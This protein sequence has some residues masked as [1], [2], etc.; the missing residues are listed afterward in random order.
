MAGPHT[1]L[2]GAVLGTPAFM[3]PE[4]ARGKWDDVDATSDLWAIG[5][6]LFMLLT[7]RSVRDEAE[8][9]NEALMYAM[10][11]PVPPV[12][13]LIPGLPASIAS[14]IDRAL[15]FEKA[16]RFADAR[17]MKTALERAL[18]LTDK[19][20]WD[21]ILD[22]SPRGLNAT[23]GPTPFVHIR[24]PEGL[25][26]AGQLGN[27]T[28]SSRPPEMSAIPMTPAPAKLPMFAGPIVPRTPSPARTPAAA[29][30]TLSRAPLARTVIGSFVVAL[31]IGV[32]AAAVWLSQDPPAARSPSAPPPSPG[33]VDSLPA[34]AIAPASSANGTN[35]NPDNAAPQASGTSADAGPDK[36]AGAAKPRGTARPPVTAKPPVDP[37]D[38]GRF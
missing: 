18:A 20:K 12:G 33:T 6:T 28:P 14:V 35:T 27:T 4:Q 29:P 34:N 9:T 7:N 2:G 36:G 22:M 32:V 30:S 13:T 15:S 37:L 10:T 5:A 38:R 31:A 16:D 3:P 24:T 23:G 26:T 25:G 21:T 8:T 17:T 1:T 11:K 19:E